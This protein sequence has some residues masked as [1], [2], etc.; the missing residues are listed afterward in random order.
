M[1]CYSDHFIVD[2]KALA[3]RLAALPRPLVFTNGCFDLLHRGHVDYLDQAAALGQ[4][5][6]VGVNSDASVQRLGKGND[7]PINKLEDRLAVLAS[8]RCVSLAVPFEEDTPLRL[9]EAI[10]PDQ[11]VKG[12]DWPIADIVGAEFVASHG[13]EVH[14]IPFRFQRSTTELLARIRASR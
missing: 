8:L 4:S 3:A 14:S 12:G 9:I 7:R 5:L 13:G 11:L 2:S 6:V 1:S 10:R